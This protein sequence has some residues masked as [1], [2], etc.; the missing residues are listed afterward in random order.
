MAFITL[1]L[2]LIATV[3]LVSISSCAENDSAFVV[4]GETF[5]TNNLS[6]AQENTPFEIFM[7]KIESVSANVD[8]YRFSI[9]GRL[10]RYL[11]NNT[12]TLVIRNEIPNRSIEF[13]VEQTN[14]KFLDQDVTNYR[15]EALALSQTTIYR[16]AT[17]GPL[18]RL[19]V[20]CNQV[21]V[22]LYTD[23]LNSDDSLT[24][25]KSML[26]SQC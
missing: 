4:E 1:K 24:L 13:T 15:H 21:Y 17:D 19:Q 8:D 20:L 12:Q 2:L 22:I 18:Q 9:Q 26:P 6:K 25:M 3:I 10:K 14:K 16:L 5:L 7:P 11:K 23:D